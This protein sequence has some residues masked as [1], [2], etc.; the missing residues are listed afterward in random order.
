MCPSTP[1]SPAAPTVKLAKSKENVAEPPSVV[2]VTAKPTASGS[3]QLY[4]ASPLSDPP[5]DATV[6]PS[7]SVTVNEVSPQ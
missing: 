2:A 3:T 5:P 4:V 1:V 6:L 7:A